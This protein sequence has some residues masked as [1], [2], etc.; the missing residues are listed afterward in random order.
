MCIRDRAGRSPGPPRPGSAPGEPLAR[1]PWTTVRLA[2]SS[3]SATL[4]LVWEGYRCRR[5]NGTDCKSRLAARVAWR[6]L[7]APHSA[8][9]PVGRSDDIR[10]RLATQ[11]RL[12]DVCSIPGL[13][14]HHTS[15]LGYR[16]PGAPAGRTPARPAR[17]FAVFG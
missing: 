10:V 3:P 8:S 16:G 13:P 7:A 11:E 2:E 6:P 9:R 17:P 5:S 15:A 14:T 4:S 12:S 1:S